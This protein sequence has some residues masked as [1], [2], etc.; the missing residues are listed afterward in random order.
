V[1][2][3]SFSFSHQD[4][5]SLSFSLVDE[6]FTNFSFSIRQFQSCG[7]IFVIVLVSSTKI[8]DF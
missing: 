4:T 7:R 3:L 2:T 8:S 1:L 5:F 6:N